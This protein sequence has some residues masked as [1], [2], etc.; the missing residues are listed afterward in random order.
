MLLDEGI[1]GFVV[2]QTLNELFKAG[3]E[4]IELGCKLDVLQLRNVNCRGQSQD[5]RQ[6]KTPFHLVLLT[7][8]LIYG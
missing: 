5:G 1:S 6:G 7:N 3:M 8:E 2:L 4:T